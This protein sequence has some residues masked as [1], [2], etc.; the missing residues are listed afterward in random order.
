MYRYIVCQ[1]ISARAV[2]L[3]IGRPRKIPETEDTVQE[4]TNTAKETPSEATGADSAAQGTVP[5]AMASGMSLTAAHWVNPTF[6]EDTLSVAVEAITPQADVE[7][8]K[9]RPS[10]QRNCKKNR[11][12]QVQLTCKLVSPS[13]LLNVNLSLLQS[14]QLLFCLQMEQGLL[15]G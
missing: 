4:A 9:L 3:T 14:K 5:L 2:R 1:R 12:S 6:V 10:L 15:S 7:R 13:R 8:F 11:T